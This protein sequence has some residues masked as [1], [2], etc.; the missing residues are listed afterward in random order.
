[1]CEADHISKLVMV[2]ANAASETAA[3]ARTGVPLTLAMCSR[4]GLS[5]IGRTIDTHMISYTRVYTKS[6]CGFGWDR[7]LVSYEAVVGARREGGA[8]RL[9]RRVAP[10]TSCA[11]CASTHQHGCL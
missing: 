10:P 7:E 5:H 6:T 11:A 9:V 3:Q 4:R 1:M 2:K 8:G